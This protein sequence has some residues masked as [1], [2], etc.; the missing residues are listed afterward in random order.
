MKISSLGLNALKTVGIVAA[1]LLVS[2]GTWFGLQAALNTTNPWVVVTSGSM[3]PAY[4]R[5]DL[6]LVQGVEN[7]STIEVG[8][9][10]T[11]HNPVDQDM[12]VVHRVVSKVYLGEKLY[13]K[14]QG[15]NR[16]TN[17]KPDPWNLD[18]ELVTG[19]VLFKVPFVGHM[20]FVMQ[21]KAGP[22]ILAILVIAIFMVDAFST[23]RPPASED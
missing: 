10:I 19:V 15:D 14:T 1:A 3:M 2:Y 20:V 18:P 11:F 9:V 21:S 23:D 13:F 8:D 6:L 16:K 5:G 22:F 4:Y 7:K 12:L 17:P